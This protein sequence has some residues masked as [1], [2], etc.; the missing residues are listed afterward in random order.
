M[1]KRKKTISEVAQEIVADFK[2][3]GIMCNI[4][5]VNLLDIHSLN[6]WTI[7]G[8][9]DELINNFVK[10]AEYVEWKGMRAQ[11]LRTQLAATSGVEV[12]HA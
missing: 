4:W 1:L 8:N 10:S 2:H 11:D 5:L 3:H 7:I 12:P 9:K 6:D